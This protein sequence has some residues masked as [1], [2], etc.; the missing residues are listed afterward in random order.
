[1]AD[2]ELHADYNR[3]GRLEGTAAEYALR[4]ASPG[5]IVVPNLDVDS[6]RLP[7][8]VTLG[9]RVTLDRDQP[10]VLANDDEAVPIRIVVNN[11][12]APAGSRFFLRPTGFVSTRVRI[13]D[14][15]GRILP[16]DTAR[17]TDIPVA[18]PAIPGT[19]NLTLT[20]KTLPGSPIGH[21]TD[22][23]TRF[24]LDLEEESAFQVQLVSV[25][26]AGTEVVRDQ[27]RFTVAPFVVLDNASS[28]VRVYVCDL[29]ANQPSVIE[30]RDALRLI[31]GVPLVT[32][33][34]DVASGDTWLQDQF[35]HALIQGSDGWRQVVLHLPRL[36]SDSSNGS[37]AGNL[38]NFVVS[39]FPSRDIG[40]FDDL[41]KREL[42]FLDSSG[43]V[44]R[45]GFR[46]CDRLALVMQLPYAVARLLIDSLKRVDPTFAPNPP[47]TGPNGTLTWP[48]VLGWL[49]N[50]VAEFRRRAREAGEA[51]N[52]EWKATL[53]GMEADANQRAN[54]VASRLPLN[55]GAGVVG[56]PTTTGQIEVT[57]PD[58]ERIFQR[59]RQLHSSSNYGGNIEASPPTGSAALG[60]LVIGNGLIGGEH[61][62]MD[63]DLL[64]LL[65]KQRKQPMVQ[66]NTT[67]LDVGHV[68]E[69]MAFA[70]DRHGSG[71]TFAVLRAS[72]LL[73]LKLIEEAKLQYLTGLSD[74]HP[75]NVTGRISGVLPRLTTEGT[76]PVTRLFRGRVW[77]HVHPEPKD[78]EEIPQVLEP[79]R[80]YQDV[81]Q[82]M[83][84]GDPVDPDSGGINIHGIHY[85]PGEGPNRT[86]PA[87]ISVREVL[88]GE[89]DLDGESTNA[90][91]ESAYIADAGER[92]REEFPSARILPL[93]VLFDRV[94]STKQWEAD[95]E[96]FS[97]SAFTPD[98]VNLQVI[99]GRLLVP[100][101]Y[102][103][104]M[105][106]P[107]AIAVLTA[108]TAE[109]GLPDTLLRRIDARFVRR[110]DLTTGVY[111]M[112]RDAAISRPVPGIG[113]V[114]PV[115]GG[116]ETETDVIE[117][118]RDSY[119]GATDAE[120]RENII[121]PNHRHFDG[122]GRLRDGWRRFTLHETMVDIFETYIQA[123][124]AELDVPLSWVD[125][126][127]YHVHAG[128]I[129]CGTNVL[130][131]PSRANPLPNVWSVADLQYGGQPM[132]F[133]EMDISAPAR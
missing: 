23:N 13:N 94:A 55:Q 9:S 71:S 32:V 95:P 20:T 53:E 28:A 27:A 129:H 101:P 77:S 51:G 68:D 2:Y 65:F 105:R 37:N 83:N 87:D 39:H 30:V 110:H 133:E 10:V 132:Q 50:L 99:N 45:I 124:A 35:Q 109:M 126:W 60:K 59:I 14:A 86:Y 40:M 56:L 106:L 24:A 100:R 19:L 131:M 63:P 64:Q 115:Y 120:L 8:S 6:R 66:L 62:F 113:T 114:R 21:V 34:E 47:R 108:A 16:W 17:P 26:A 111:W 97:T 67:W 22:L 81:S 73:A 117:Q 84:G 31:G 52:V 44:R 72:S 82:A 116:L 119:P 91:I 29:P 3:N 42:E 33:P 57:L 76:S 104:R 41:W 78:A 48:D 25:D 69:I 70:P 89:N 5:A 61:D 46:E 18:V 80:I 38:E 122:L 93:P 12:S 43:R 1:M 107:D 121:R 123:V 85:W 92:L 4:V 128:G 58:A 75:H 130:R 112:Q 54:Q 103:P 88:Y 11:A 36:R 98:V 127:Y 7:S 96:V 74:D 49:P 15:G 125:S 118:F 102:G 90:Y 79:P